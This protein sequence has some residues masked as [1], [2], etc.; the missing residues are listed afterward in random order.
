MD[1]LFQNHLLQLRFEHLG[2][3]GF[4]DLEIQ[5]NKNVTPGPRFL[6]YKGEWGDPVV[7][8]KLHYFRNAE[9]TEPDYSYFTYFNKC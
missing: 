5:E 4:S 2:I 6:S 8:G 7:I 1:S 9:Q 3:K